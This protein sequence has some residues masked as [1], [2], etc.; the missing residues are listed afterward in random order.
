MPQERL[1]LILLANRGGVWWGNPLDEAQIEKSPFAAAFL[2]HF[3]AP[4]KR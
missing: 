4:Q 3:P 1:T 2:E